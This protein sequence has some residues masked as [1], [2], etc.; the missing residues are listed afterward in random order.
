MNHSMFV[1]LSLLLWKVL[2][3]NASDRTK[4][5]SIFLWICCSPAKFLSKKDRSG[6]KFGDPFPGLEHGFLQ[7][8]GIR[9]VHCWLLKSAHRQLIVDCWLLN[10]D[11]QLLIIEHMHQSGLLHAR[12]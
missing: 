5:D 3:A 7:A 1:V 2:F 9:Q 10:V 8:N 11:N 12:S 6:I 4:C